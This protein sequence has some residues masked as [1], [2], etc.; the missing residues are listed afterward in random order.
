MVLN[1]ARSV[2]DWTGRIVREEKRGTHP[3][4][5]VA[6]CL[7]VRTVGTQTTRELLRV[8][9]YLMFRLEKAGIQDLLGDYLTLWGGG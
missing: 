3:T 8:L 7:A 5:L 2:D 4:A 1:V 9:A 6:S